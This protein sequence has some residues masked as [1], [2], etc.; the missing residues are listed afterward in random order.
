MQIEEQVGVHVHAQT[1]NNDKE[2]VPTIMENEDDAQFM[3]PPP[4]TQFRTSAL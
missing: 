3:I 2:E 4:A 1:N